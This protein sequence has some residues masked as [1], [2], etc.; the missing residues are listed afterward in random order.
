M[1]KLRNY[2]LKFENIYYYKLIGL[3]GW[4]SVNP[5]DPDLDLAIK[6]PAS[7]GSDMDLNFYYG[8][9]SGSRLIRSR[10]GSFIGVLLGHLQLGGAKIAHE[11]YY[12][13]E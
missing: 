1:I 6:D 8:S 12:V 11:N 13:H 7:N 10:F 5:P 3:T 2:Y 4:V 9:G